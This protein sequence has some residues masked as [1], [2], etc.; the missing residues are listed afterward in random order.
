MTLNDAAQ[1]AN[2]V[3]AAAAVAGVIAY[4]TWKRQPQWEH[5]RDVA[6]AAYEAVAAMEHAFL[7]CIAAYERAKEQLAG[8]QSCS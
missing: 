4:F 6:S 5:G 1:W 3:M 7:Q 8:V 2:I